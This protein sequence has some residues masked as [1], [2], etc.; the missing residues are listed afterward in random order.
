MG[1]SDMQGRRFFRAWA[2]VPV[3]VVVAL[4]GSLLCTAPAS[5]SAKAV[6]CTSLTG[7]L[8]DSP[9]TFTLSGCSTGTGGSGTAQGFTISWAN[10]RTTSL[11]TAAFP[12]PTGR[13]QHGRCASLADRYAIKDGIVGDS[14]GAIRVGG[15][16]SADVCILNEAP[17]PWSLVPGSVFKL[18]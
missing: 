6:T 17:D 18:R 11:A 3:L 4:A 5:A 2:T 15:Q 9:I 14:T 13:V 10:G 12:V 7:D 8:N 1:G 16:A